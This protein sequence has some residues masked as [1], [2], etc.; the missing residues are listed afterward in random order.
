LRA[1]RRAR[2]PKTEQTTLDP[3]LLKHSAGYALFLDLDGTLIDIALTP[4]GVVAPPGLAKLLARLSAALEGALAII[5]GRPVCDVDRLLQPLEL[6]TAGV[7]GAQLRTA[8][9]GPVVETAERLDPALVAAVQDLAAID[10]G[11][12][13]EPKG[14][15]IAVHYRLAAAAGPQIVARLREI[16]EAAPQRAE[17]CLGRKVVEVVPQY[18]SKGGA[19]KTIMSL[20]KFHGRA[21]IMIGDDA[22]DESALRAAEQA[23][24]LGLR[25]RGEHFSDMATDFESPAHVR[26]WLAGFAD[27]VMV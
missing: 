6:V 19:L 8:V 10:P 18:V 22:T 1:V 3:A 26:A 12:I 5:T 13:V 16:L 2:R 9:K 7:H 27:S 24:G 4:D 23:G 17:L 14:V 11:I 20:P 15:S 21:P 25:V